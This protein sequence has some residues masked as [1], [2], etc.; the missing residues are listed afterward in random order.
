[1]HGHVIVVVGSCVCKNDARAEAADIFDDGMVGLVVD[2]QVPIQKAQVYV[3]PHAE[4]V[5]NAFRFLVAAL[6]DV[7]FLLG[8]R[9]AFRTRREN[10][11]ADMRPVVGQFAEGA[12][13]ADD[14]VIGMRTEDQ[15]LHGELSFLNPSTR[16]SPSHPV[17]HIDGQAVKR[18]HLPTEFSERVL[19]HQVVEARQNHVVPVVP[20]SPQ[21]H[22]QHGNNPSAKG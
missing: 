9:V 15:N 7:R 14:L 2:L 22:V 19:N 18:F 5:A 21:C 4:N 12:P 13:H 16:M 1:V 3:L 11:E 20:H 17:L 6:H 8:N 10:H